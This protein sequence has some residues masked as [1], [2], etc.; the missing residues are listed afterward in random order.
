MAKNY[1]NRISEV[2][3]ELQTQ[4]QSVNDAW[5]LLKEGVERVAESTLEKM[6]TDRRQ[7]WFDKECN[8]A[9]QKKNA[10]YR[11]MQQRSRTRGAE[12]KYK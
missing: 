3:K 8:T 12:D 10:V 5:R 2:I 11:E 9:T 6:T 1:K 7:P 4:P